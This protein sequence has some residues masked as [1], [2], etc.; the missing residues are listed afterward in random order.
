VK[1]SAS[2]LKPALR[3]KLLPC[4]LVTGDEMLLVQR[5]L[6]EIRA[7]ARTQG[8]G[9]RELYVATTGFDWRQVS[10][11]A[12]SLSLFAEQRIIE[13]RL[14]TGKPGRDG[15][16]AIAELAESAREDLVVLVE[17]PKLDNSALAS[18][19]VRALDAA[20]AVLQ[21]W[22]IGPREL[23]RWIGGA[24]RDAGLEPDSEAVRLLA[25][26]VEGNLLA[27]DQEIQKLALLLGEG[28]VTAADIVNAV[29]DSSRYDAFKLVDAAVAGQGARALRM[30]G[31]LRAEGVDAVPVV[32]VL[33]RELRMLAD[34]AERVRAGAELGAAMQKARVWSSRQGIVRA[35]LRRHGTADLYRLLQAAQRADAAAKGQIPLDPWQL[36]MDV[37][38]GLAASWSRA[39]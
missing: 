10:E 26:R 8:F 17:A 21:I 35:C 30:L 16:A 29:A 33:T 34:L 24:M 27:A 4:Y 12:A 11:A 1:L 7:A 36:V 18:R 5:A 25:E 2:Q 13:I 22:P 32:W 9:A 23:P 38:F 3:K 15:S 14:P 37:V 31:R 20:G 19:W 28:P 6:D 39:A